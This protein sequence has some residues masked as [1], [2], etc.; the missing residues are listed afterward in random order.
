MLAPGARCLGAFARVARSA[1]A[2]PSG[3][4]QPFLA[5][6]WVNAKAGNAKIIFY[7]VLR[8]EL[9]QRAGNFQRGF[10]VGTVALCQAQ[11]ARIAVYMYV[12]RYNQSARGN[13]PAAGVYG[14]FSHHPAQK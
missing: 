1:M 3:K 10:H 13:M 4:R 5:Q 7:R 2:C 11:Q 9:R 12:Q 8:A 6:T 14:V